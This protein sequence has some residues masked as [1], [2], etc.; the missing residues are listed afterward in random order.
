MVT[1]TMVMDEIAEEG[2]EGAKEESLNLG[3][4]N[5]SIYH[6]VEKRGRI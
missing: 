2:R 4:G 5:S 6:C 1:E 3:S